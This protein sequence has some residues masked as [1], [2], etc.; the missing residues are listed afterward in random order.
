MAFAAKAGAFLM[1]GQYI[2]ALSSARKGLQIYPNHTPSFL[3]AIASLMRL[4]RVTE[5]QAMAHE[6]ENIYPGYWILKRW[7]VLEHFCD[8]LR[9][10]GLPE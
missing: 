9:G 1:Q 6:Y 10:A 5:A 3:I 2:E 4:D 7:P 8:E